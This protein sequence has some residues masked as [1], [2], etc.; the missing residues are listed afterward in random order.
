[1]N[2]K[3]N[4]KTNNDFNLLVISDE[5]LCLTDNNLCTAHGQCVSPP[6]A[7]KVLC[8]CNPGFAGNFCQ[9]EEFYYMIVTRKKCPLIKLPLMCEI[10]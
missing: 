9:C 5:D 2:I 1:M 6:G 3:S 10:Y 4:R 7:N 8:I